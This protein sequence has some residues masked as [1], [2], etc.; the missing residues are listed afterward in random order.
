MKL[1]TIDDINKFISLNNLSDDYDVI[2]NLM[3]Y[4]SL[5]IVQRFVVTYINSRDYLVRC[6]VYE[7]LGR[8]QNQDYIA[9]LLK[10]L[11]KD[12]S[13]IAKTYAIGAI[14][15]LIDESYD[16]NSLNSIILK[17]YL[18]SR[19]PR[20]RIAYLSVL[21]KL[22]GD[23][24]YVNKMLR[25]IMHDDYHI[26]YVLLHCLMGIVDCYNK[27]HI[28]EELDNWI[29][30]E[31]NKALRSDIKEYYDFIVGQET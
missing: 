1:E 19:S 16:Y 25:Y 26:R 5:K 11:D 14:C 24:E 12:D 4:A 8:T 27:N 20:M 29:H 18:K 6:N 15:E 17:K 9:V 30:F 22:E 13:A 2:D 10:C 21:Y 7:F 28:L 23:M 3:D 31:G